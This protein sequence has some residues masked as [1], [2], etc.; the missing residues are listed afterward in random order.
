MGHFAIES[1]LCSDTIAEGMRRLSINSWKESLNKHHQELR[2]EIRINNFLPELRQLPLTPIEYERIK[3]K[4]DNISQV[5]ELIETLRTK[6]RKHFDQ[7]CSVLERNGYKHWARKLRG[8][9]SGDE[10]DFN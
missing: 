6:T 4:T 10:G 9:D 5:D 1:C 3:G 8:E 7:F 2:T